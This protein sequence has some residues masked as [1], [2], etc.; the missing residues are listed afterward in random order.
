MN[1]NAPASMRLFG[2]VTD[3]IVDGPGFRTSIFTQG[4]PHHCE[5]C[6]N[7]ESH[8]FDAGTEWKLEDIE[9]RF[10]GNPLL[11]GITL[12]GGEPF[13]QPAACAELARRAHAKGLDVWVYSGYV[14]EQ[15]CQM[16]EANEDIHA[17]LHA[18]DVLVDGPFLLKERSLELTFCGSRN[19]RVIDLPKT[20]E[21]GIVTRYQA[22]EW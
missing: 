2:L 3:S 8:A 17:L 18:C 19:Q 5:G 6:H 4:C 13:A 10:T 12:S 20:F 21:S 15:L 9:A 14:Y 11:S 16:A 22:P 1:P 7:P